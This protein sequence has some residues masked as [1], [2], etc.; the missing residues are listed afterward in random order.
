MYFETHKKERFE[1]L[2]RKFFFEFFE[3]INRI[4]LGYSMFSLSVAN[5]SIGIPVA[6]SSVLIIPIAI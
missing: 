3:N 5:P 6:S 4:K 2:K 1:C